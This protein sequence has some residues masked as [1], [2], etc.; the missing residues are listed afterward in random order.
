MITSRSLY[1]LRRGVLGVVAVLPL[2]A[3]VVPG[4]ASAAPAPQEAESFTF[5]TGTAQAGMFSPELLAGELSVG[6]IVGDAVAG[7]QDETARAASTSFAVPLLQSAGGFTVCGAPAPDLAAGL[8]QPLAVDTAAS[9]NREP[10][11]RAEPASGQGP[12]VQKASAQ[13]GAASNATT[14]LGSFG[15]PGLAD[16]RGAQAHASVVADAASQRR[17][18]TAQTT[19]GSIDVLGGL[20]RFEGMRWELTQSQVGPD[21]R[22]DQRSVDAQF[23]MDGITIDA[24]AL[25]GPIGGLPGLDQLT[26]VRLPITQP[27][28]LG[29]VLAQA[30]QL[31]APLGLQIRLPERVDFE[32]T[33]RH[34]LTPLEIALGGD[35]FLLRPIIGPLLNDPAV[36]QVQNAL[37]DGLFDPQECEQLGGIFKAIPEL[38][39]Y[40]NTFGN[41]APLLIAA[42]TGVVSGG[43]IRLS[44]G[45]VSTQ[46]DNRY[47]APP[48]LGSFATPQLTP[49]PPAAPPSP[50]AAAPSSPTPAA[51]PS[52]VP[53][54]GTETAAP[55]S[56]TPASFTT[57]CETTSPAGRP[58]CWLGR[59]PLA[60]LL[61]TVFAVATLAGDEV[62]RRRRSAAEANPQE[63]P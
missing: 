3:M 21:D 54:S 59:A 29:T 51:T 46:L 30:N 18:A 38:N 35:D 26:D 42:T 6:V 56:P 13:P 9:G 40:Y 10:A 57:D 12:L 7:Y 50:P 45:G 20:L 53:T 23:T 37:I 44:L 19:I 24:G 58:G 41:Y 28:E 33:D 2:L 55:V 4:G 34:A 22:N 63:I 17:T 61:V 49:S 15:L 5:G 52:S 14:E 8:P 39:V 43:E 48:D 1:R 11:S 27:D 62:H 25:A 31:L 36:G 60:G 32:G 16:I 47:F